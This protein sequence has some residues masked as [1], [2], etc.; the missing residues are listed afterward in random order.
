MET[1][2]DL[3]NDDLSAPLNYVGVEVTIFFLREPN[4]NRFS[5]ETN[6]NI[7]LVFAIC[8]AFMCEPCAL[9]IERFRASP[10]LLNILGN[11]TNT[12]II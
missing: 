11:F 10:I 7:F 6:M 9:P 12:E 8:N 3:S 5:F 1:R 2:L 4:Q